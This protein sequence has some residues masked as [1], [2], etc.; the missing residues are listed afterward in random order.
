MLYM[1][2]TI[3][4]AILRFYSRGSKYY[5]TAYKSKYA[6][7]ES[8]HSDFEPQ[9]MMFAIGMFPRLLARKAFKARRC[10]T[11]AFIKY[12]QARQHEHGSA[13]VQARYQHSSSFGVSPE[14]IAGVEVGGAFAVL[15]STA[16]AC[17]WVIYHLFSDPVILKE[18]RAEVLAL[19][20]DQQGVSSIDVTSIKSKC[21]ILL[22]TLQE[23]LRFR[24]ISVSARVVL[25]DEKLLD[26]KYHLKK[27]GML[28]IPVTVMHSDPESWG[29]TASVFDHRRFLSTDSKQG[30]PSAKGSTASPIPRTAYRP[31]G[32]GHVLCPGRHFATTEILAFAALVILRFD[33]NPVAGGKWK[34]A[35]IEKSS[36]V[37]ALPTPD[38]PIRV[39]ISPRE[40][41]RAWRVELVE[42]DYAVSVASED[43]TT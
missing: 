10:L 31:F 34:D 36:L 43:S 1:G 38:D 9:I 30:I 2:H 20:H 19:V 28:M 26:G 8:Y 12:M 3:L 7:N 27:G 42:S 33:I 6:L 37:A 39:K 24:H 13:L 11:D 23:V 21:P 22:S 16:P 35:T 40:Q 25:Q 41:S 32:G 14:D 4:S 5:F 18:C 29:Q 17:F 15:G